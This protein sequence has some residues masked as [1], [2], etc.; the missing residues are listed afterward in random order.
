[1]ISLKVTSQDNYVEGRSQAFL[2]YLEVLTSTRSDLEVFMIYHKDSRD[3]F[4]HI[5][6]PVDML[7]YPTVPPSEGQ[8]GYYR[9]KAVT[10]LMRC[11]EDAEEILR[12]AQI[13]LDEFDRSI[14][15]GDSVLPS[16]IFTINP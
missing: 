4:S 2:L 5:A 3:F 16:Q 6:S 13:D 11:K 7:E 1:M 12:L 10:L 8:T 14:K 9:V 15:N